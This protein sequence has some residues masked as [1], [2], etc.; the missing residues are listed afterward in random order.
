MN[1]ETK[2]QQNLNLYNHFILGFNFK[3]KDLKKGLESSLQEINSIKLSKFKPK[4]E[5]KSTILENILPELKTSLKL[6]FEN[7]EIKIEKKSIN[8]SYPKEMTP[9]LPEFKLYP[10]FFSRLEDYTKEKENI[11]V[12]EIKQIDE[13][14]KLYLMQKLFET[15]KAIE[16]SS[17]DIFAVLEI[18]NEYNFESL[19]KMLETQIESNKR[20]EMH[21]IEFEIKDGDDLFTLYLERKINVIIFYSI[22]NSD[23]NWTKPILDVLNDNINKFQE[24]VE[25]LKL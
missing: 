6:N 23:I 14:V 18:P 15:K 17:I 12:E 13:I 11:S 16:L 9:I 24:I 22:L 8:I 10:R 19:N 21:N 20:Y 3:E 2:Y 4:L 1:G 5:L 25:E 7:F